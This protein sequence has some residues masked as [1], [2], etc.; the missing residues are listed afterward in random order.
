MGEKLRVVLD[1]NIWVSITLD[2]TL[3]RNFL[4]LIRRRKIDA[5]I[6]R[7]LV[8]E[9]ARV[10]TYPR[11]QTILEEAGIEAAQ[12]L[13]NIARSAILIRTRKTVGEIREDPSAN[14]V[15]E[16]ALSAKAGLIVTGDNHLLKLREFEGIRILAAREFLEMAESRS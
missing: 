12:A 6:S 13:S 14:R 7:A 15:L 2:K 8:T 3:A 9:L 10:L 16:C 11:I 5:H 4:P 1:T